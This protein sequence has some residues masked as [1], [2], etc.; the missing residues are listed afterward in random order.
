[1]HYESR[2]GHL[3][4]NLSALELMLAVHHRAMRKDD[5]FI[6]SKGHSAGALYVTLW[7]LGHLSEDDLRQFH[8]DGSKLSGHPAPR[9]IPQVP[10][11]TGSLG[12][13]LSLAGG[14]ALG[15]LLQNQPGRVFCLLSDGEMQEGSTWEAIIFI[16][17]RDNLPLTIIVDVNGLQG[18]GSTVEITGLKLT[19]EKFREFGL[20][21]A[22][23]DGHDLGA[24]CAACGDRSSGPRVVIART[25]KG[26]GVSF[27]E[28]RMEWHYLTMTEEQ[29]RQAVEEA[30]RR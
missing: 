21:A 4:G 8:K 1:M 13:G 16:A 30:E 22:E 28:D 17:H 2:A 19:P 18:F 23:I 5:V 12:H 29:Y 6:L 14:V 11:A 15:K 26:H 3:G 10:F 27:M 9:W 20:A 24:I 7:T 25:H